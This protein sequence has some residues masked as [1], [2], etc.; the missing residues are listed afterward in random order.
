MEY[1]KLINLL[2]NTQNQ[3]SKF[4]TK[5][6]VE[7]NDDSCRTYNTNS[8]I[9]FNTL[10]LKSSLCDYN[11]AYILVKGTI[12]VRN[13]TAADI[14]ANNTN[15][16]VII[17]NCAS[18]TNC[19][20]EINNK[21]VDNVISIDVLMPMYNLIECSDN[22][23]KTSE[24]LWQYYRDK[25]ALNNADGIIDSPDDNSSSSLKFKQEKTGHTGN[26]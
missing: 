9:K 7:I 12:S 3:P 5:P 18:F 4:I 26:D 8:Q 13:T 24:N 6:W 10:M 20:S 23:P 17:Q 25:L 21:Q 19:I 11:D 15:K 14:A 22:Y 2:D 1:Q 16:K